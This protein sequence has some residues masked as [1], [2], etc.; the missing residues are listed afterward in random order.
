M[1]GNKIVIMRKSNF[2]SA[3]AIILVVLCT[4]ALF[5]LSRTPSSIIKADYVVTRTTPSTTSVAVQTV[6]KNEQIVILEK[7]GDWSTILI[8]EQKVYALTKDI[9]NETVD[10]SNLAIKV[11]PTKNQ[12]P[13][14]HD[15]RT[16]NKVV[17]T[18]TYGDIY[19]KYS[20]KGE[21]SQIIVNNDIYWV[22]TKLLKKVE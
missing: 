22:E 21:F 4:L 20:E 11:T 12:V 17:Q 10:T 18:L 5:F 7:K 15:E 14:F 16:T 3:I 2:I 1:K 19:L 6:K 13:I 8:D 9:E